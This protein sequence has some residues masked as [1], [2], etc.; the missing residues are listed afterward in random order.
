MS[1]YF[2]PSIVSELICFLAAVI[3]LMKDRSYVWRSMIIYLFLTCATEMLGVYIAGPM[4]LINNN[5]VYNI[6]LTCEIGFTHLMFAFLLGKYIN[7]RPL[8]FSG[9]AIVAFI[10]VYELYNNY[11]HH[12]IIYNINTYKATSILFVFYSLYFYYLLLKSEQYVELRYSAEFWWVA[13]ALVFYFTNTACNIFYKPLSNVLV[14]NG[15]HLTRYIFSALNILL[16][17][18][19]SYS[20]ICR[21]WILKTSK[22]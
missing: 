16:Y 11:T 14:W 22:A 2:T 10:Y 7:S 21:R 1:S 15:I 5:W 13:G 17:G 20:F 9:L 19:W 6:F 12:I 3:C 8:I 4:H 18:C